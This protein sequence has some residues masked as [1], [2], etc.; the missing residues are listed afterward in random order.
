MGKTKNTAV[1]EIDDILEG[2]NSFDKVANIY[3]RI[4]GEIVIGDP[5]Q[6][7][8]S[9]LVVIEDTHRKGGYYWELHST[10]EYEIMIE[11]WNDWDGYAHQERYPPKLSESR[12]NHMKLTIH[13]DSSGI[14][15]KVRLI[16][17]EFSREP[18]K[19]TA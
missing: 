2:Y 12:L 10:E 11:A 9:G 19:E 14:E 8:Q 15:D 16:V 18:K 3:K 7:S 5:L 13:R 17:K 1:I 6:S 4:R